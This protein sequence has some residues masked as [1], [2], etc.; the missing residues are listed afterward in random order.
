MS[1]S[2]NRLAVS[3]VDLFRQSNNRGLLS[4]IEWFNIF[5]IS[6]GLRNNSGCAS[7]G[8]WLSDDVQY[9]SAKM[10]LLVFILAYLYEI[11]ILFSN[12]F[13][14]SV[15]MFYNN[16]KVW[17]SSLQRTLGK[18][19]LNEIS[20]CNHWP[21]Y[22]WVAWPLFHLGCEK[23]HQKGGVSIEIYGSFS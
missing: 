21:V 16:F 19:P 14:L 9:C 22:N 12:N 5:C 17:I 11:Q 6:T 3:L 8:G 20:E 4:A 15:D 2:D 1:V 10:C 23:L 7:H 18:T 13:I